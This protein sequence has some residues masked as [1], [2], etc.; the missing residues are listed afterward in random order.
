MHS[1]IAIVGQLTQDVQLNCPCHSG[2][3]VSSSLSSGDVVLVVFYLFDGVFV[4]SGIAWTSVTPI[5]LAGVSMTSAAIG[6]SSAGE[7]C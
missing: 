5:L 3:Q 7:D 4:A 2:E 6:L 1:C